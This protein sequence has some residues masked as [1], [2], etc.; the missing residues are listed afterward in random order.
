L[1]PAISD[2]PLFKRD[3]AGS[4]SPEITILI[5]TLSIVFV[6]IVPVESDIALEKVWI[7][8]FDE[9]AT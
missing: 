9:G 6:A 5:T 7:S 3:N 8:G 2:I 4:D 1:A